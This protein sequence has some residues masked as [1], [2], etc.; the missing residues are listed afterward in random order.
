MSFGSVDQGIDTLM[1]HL[2]SSQISGLMDHQISGHGSNC[3]NYFFRVFFIVFLKG[4]L[5]DCKRL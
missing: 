4:R 3:K 5:I 2:I 1:D